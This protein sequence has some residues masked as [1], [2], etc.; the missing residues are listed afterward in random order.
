MSRVSIYK[1]YTTMMRCAA[2]G[3]NCK[4]LIAGDDSCVFSFPPLNGIHFLVGL[5]LHSHHPPAVP[6]F[7]SPLAFPFVPVASPTTIPS[8]IMYIRPRLVTY[9]AVHPDDHAKCGMKNLTCN[10]G[11]SMSAIF[12]VACGPVNCTKFRSKENTT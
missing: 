2:H 3:V 9:T 6:C 12:P 11:P 8:L 7:A 1:D 10:R 4:A 5:S